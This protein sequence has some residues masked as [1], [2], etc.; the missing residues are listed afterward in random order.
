MSYD[1]ERAEKALVAHAVNG[2]REALAFIGSGYTFQNVA[3]GQVAEVVGKLQAEHQAVD[4]ISVQGRLS[5]D[6]VLEAC[7]DQMSRFMVGTCLS[8][9]EQARHYQEIG[10]I[11]RAATDAIEHR[12]G[13][14]QEILARVD[15]EAQRIGS[16]ASKPV[17][18]SAAEIARA[19]LP[20]LQMVVQGILPAGL[21]VLAGHPKTGKSF[22]SLRLAG[23]VADGAVFLGRKT[24]KGTALYCDMDSGGGGDGETVSI[25]TQRR[26]QGRLKMIWGDGYSPA[27][28]IVADS[29]PPL[30]RGLLRWL[31]A[32]VEEHP[33]LK[34]VV[35]DTLQGVK[36]GRSK[37]ENAYEGDSRILAP[38][39]RWAMDKAI[40]VLAVHHLSKGTAGMDISER[41]SGSQG[42]AGKSEALW[43]LTRERG[44]NQAK[45]QIVGRELR[46]AALILE[47]GKNDMAWKLVSEDAEGFAEAQA[48]A[49][50]VC[51]HA[52]LKL[53][54]DSGGDWLGTA[55]Q[56]ENELGLRGAALTSQ[57]V[58]TFFT[59][60]SEK[61]RLNDGIV[62]SETRTATARMH[63]LRKLKPEEM[64]N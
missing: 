28:L 25:A 12:Q 2:D 24:A 54:A 8:K 46:D 40:A 39:Q 56:L 22:L 15:R 55:G 19:D 57:K 3:A 51:I 33:G 11:F 41:L 14:P 36:G 31:D 59:K 49:N 45:L 20:P 17:T 44:E 5:D 13:S 18:V 52:I 60:W 64:C 63:R 7:F 43:M 16:V 6:A 50:D 53:V 37:T 58:R 1:E 9:L 23:A 62:H 29:A 35:L 47:H 48:Y 27:G 10:S 30:D 21:T 26:Y 38:L 34:L 32:A 42:I 4:E 61:L